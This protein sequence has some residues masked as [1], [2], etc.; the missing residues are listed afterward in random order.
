MRTLSRQYLA[1]Y[2]TLYAATLIASMVVIVIIEMMLNL[3]DAIEFSGGVSGVAAYLFLRLPSYYLPY[4]LPVCSFAAAIFCLGLPA[5]THEVLAMKASGI[6]PQRTC[7]PLLAA[8]GAIAAATLV[9]NETIV[10]DTTS[11]FKRREDGGDETRLFQDRGSFWYHRGPYLY[12]VEEADRQTRTFREVRVY[13]RDAQGQLIRSISAPHASV[14]L[15]HAWELRDAIVRDFDP[16]DPGSAPAVRIHAHLPL[17]VASER[18][19]A[20]LNA[21][22]AALSLFDLRD[23]IVAQ[24]QGGR[25]PTRYRA[26]FHARL[27]DPFT[28]FLFALLGIPVGLSVERSRSLAAAAVRG[29][30]LLGTFYT[31]QVFGGLAANSGSALAVPFPWIML[32]LFTVFGAWRFAKTSE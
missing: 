14:D 25:D 7:I 18:E 31:L 5:R 16:G 15:A 21:E 29:V 23:Y 8:A 6:P 2:L 11:E 28:V 26:L 20:L 12:S 13:E 4:L 27:A 1:S 3:D 9:M 19:L 22:P 30:V 24:A 17:E 10:L 32:G